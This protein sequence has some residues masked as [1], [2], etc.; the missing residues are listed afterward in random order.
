MFKDNDYGGSVCVGYLFSYFL[1]PMFLL[2][3]GS[4]LLSFLSGSVSRMCKGY[5][6]ARSTEVPKIRQHFKSQ[7]IRIQDF[8][9]YE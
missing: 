7:M 9:C 6:L 4:L 5:V 1:L 2:I 8:T 3:T